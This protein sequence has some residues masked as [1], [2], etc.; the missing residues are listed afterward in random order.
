MAKHKEIPVGTK[1]KVLA[2]GKDSAWHRYNKKDTL[3]MPGKIITII[4]T[5]SALC[6]KK[7]MLTVDFKCDSLERPNELN[8]CNQMRIKVIS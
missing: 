6:N 8:T 1:A 5:D 2:I 4:S 3:Y 7:G